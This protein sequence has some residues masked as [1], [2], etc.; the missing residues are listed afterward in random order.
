MQEFL[1][2]ERIFILT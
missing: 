2:R 1:K